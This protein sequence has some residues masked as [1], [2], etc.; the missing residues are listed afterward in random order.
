MKL[1]RLLV[2]WDDASSTFNSLG[3][4]I[5][6]D[7][8]EAILAANGVVAPTAQDSLMTFDVTESVSAWAAGA[9]NYGWVVLPGGTDGWRWDTAESLLLTDRPLLDVTY[10]GDPVDI[11]PD[12]TTMPEPGIIGWLSLGGMLALRRARRY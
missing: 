9:P 8:V 5:A 11:I 3:S 12:H 4:G 7:A 1:F 6:A 10:R 2:P